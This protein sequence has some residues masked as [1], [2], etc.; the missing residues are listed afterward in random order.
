MST[1]LTITKEKLAAL[2]VLV[3]DEMAEQLLRAA[4][5]TETKAAKE[6]GLAVA[7]KQAQPAGPLDAALD[8]LRAVLEQARQTRGDEELVKQIDAFTNSLKPTA[9]SGPKRLGDTDKPEAERT[10]EMG[11]GAFFEELGIGGPKT[12]A[13]R[14]PEDFLDFMMPGRTKV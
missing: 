12:K 5:S 7:L 2:R 1:R 3:G 6:H 13:T 14:E 11:M 10:K 8:R 4:L 9:G